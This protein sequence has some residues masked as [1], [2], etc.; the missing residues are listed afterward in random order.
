MTNIESYSVMRFGLQLGHYA[1]ANTGT[2]QVDIDDV[3][4]AW[5]P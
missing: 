2:L 4:V 1:G 5:V 3:Y